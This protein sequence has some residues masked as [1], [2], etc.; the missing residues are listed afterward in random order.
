LGSEAFTRLKDSFIALVEN[1]LGI[2]RR[3]TVEDVEGIFGILI[4]IYKQS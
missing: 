2:E 3:K 1:V 4:D